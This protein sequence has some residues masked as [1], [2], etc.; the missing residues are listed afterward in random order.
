MYQHLAPSFAG[1][2]P[3]V[4][5]VTSPLA[6]LVLL[7]T[8]TGCASIV[9]QGGFPEVQELAS[10]RGI[11][12][13]L[14]WHDD[15]ASGQAKREAVERLLAEDLSAGSAV[16]LALLNSP[17]LQATY[18]ELGLAQADVVQ[19]G[20]VKNPTLTAAALFGGVSPTYDFDI[21]QNF[22]DALF[23]PA[24]SRISEAQ[25]ERARLQV[26]GEVF[27]LTTK[28]RAAFYTL[29]G[30]E[31]LVDVLKV[32]LESAEAS[33]EFARNL[34]AA[35]NL[36]DLE[37]E[38]ERALVE[39][40]RAELMRA[41]AAVVKPREELRELLG[42]SGSSGRF[43]IARGLPGVPHHEP[44][45]NS[46]LALASESNL[47]LAAANKERVVLTESLGTARTWRYF[48]GIE[49][50]AETHREQGE[51]NW[52]SGPS[53]SVELPIFD[54]RQADIFR[55]ESELRQS[56]RRAES[57]AVSVAA[58][59]RR[60][61]GALESARTLSEHYRGALL[62]VR[63]RVV[64]L[65]QEHYNFMLLGAFELLRAKREEITGYSDYV[66]AVGDYWIARAELEEAVGKRIPLEG[67]LEP[68]P[69]PLAGERPMSSTHAQ[70]GSGASA[71]KQRTT[72]TTSSPAAG[73]HH[74]EH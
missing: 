32:V 46:L 1:A 13:T 54:Q 29:Q 70:H 35:G 56:E 41:R 50:G 34:H 45:L 47:E 27:K 43:E 68:T 73:R 4:A 6:A 57:A 7:V 62:P 71:S 69:L 63:R 17:A 53:L 55:L 8:L 60:A 18:E 9:R 30:A 48:G 39:D 65:S 12:E 58:D 37:L 26:A 10:Q 5:R 66:Q 14:E 38:T 44:P 24:R 15:E 51:K 3:S 64:E 40:V 33:G 2:P 20:L 67:S 25:F 59:V 42:L 36:S 22:L 11:S 16:Q 21:V 52:V 49:V 19:A 72:S 31:Q 23:I 74:G 61:Y 28:V